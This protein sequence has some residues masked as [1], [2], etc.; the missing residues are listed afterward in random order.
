MDDPNF[1]RGE[2]GAFLRARREAVP[3]AASSPGARRR[4]TPG[5]RREEVADLSG[6]SPVWYARIEQGREVSPSPAALA[7]IAQAL[8]L[9]R[10]ERR[11][12]F[13]L[14]GKGDPDG[15]KPGEGAA[16]PILKALVERQEE[17][18][19]LLDRQWNVAAFNPAAVTLFGSWL[20]APKPNLLRFVFLDPAAR[21]LIVDWPDRARRLVAEFRAD[22]V[23]SLSEPDSA[24]LVEALL[25][26]ADFATW[27]RERRVLGREGGLRRFHH[28]ERGAIAFE[29]ATLAAPEEPGFKLVLLAARKDI[30]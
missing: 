27:W 2:L 9:G 21:S 26:D 28:P 20:G 17:P 6:I 8:R 14:A 22:Q 5:L 3:A 1:R 4:R 7:R 11:H 15:E 12:L 23:R 29:Q 24:L 30:L 10:A 18:A 19:Y 25:V 16:P 13:A